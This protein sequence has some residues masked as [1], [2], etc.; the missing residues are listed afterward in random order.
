MQKDLID[1]IVAFKKNEPVTVKW[2]FDGRIKEE[3]IDEAIE[4][5]KTQF[6]TKPNF[7]VGFFEQ[8]S[9]DELNPTNMAHEAAIKAFIEDGELE[10]ILTLVLKLEY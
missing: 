7:K 3:N 2:A 5:I 1:A 8:L 10:Q 6:I 9:L 4:A